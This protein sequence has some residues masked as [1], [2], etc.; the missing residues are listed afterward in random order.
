MVVVETP[1]RTAEVTPAYGMREVGGW[2]I[3]GW[4][5]WCGTCGFLSRLYLNVRGAQK[6]AKTHRC[7]TTSRTRRNP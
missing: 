7:D 2:G 6:C 3:R 5:A 4:R 1:R